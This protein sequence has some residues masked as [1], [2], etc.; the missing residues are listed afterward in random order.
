[1]DLSWR[2]SLFKIPDLSRFASGIPHTGRAARER[3]GGGEGEEKMNDDEIN[4]MKNDGG[5]ITLK[6]KK[7]RRSEGDEKIGKGELEKELKEE[8]RKLI[9][10]K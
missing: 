3:G 1:M 6:M 9:R 7:R 8:K 10:K 4:A 2:K 5:N